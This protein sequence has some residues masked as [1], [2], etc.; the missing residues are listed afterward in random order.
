M[1]AGKTIQDFFHLDLDGSP[2]WPIGWPCEVVYAPAVE[3]CP[4]LRSLVD[5][6]HGPNAFQ[7]YVARFHKGPFRLDM[8]MAN[9]LTK[10]LS[11]FAPIQP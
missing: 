6:L 4:V 1:P 11:N 5:K 8:K 9:E 7:P 2:R 3:Q 10:W